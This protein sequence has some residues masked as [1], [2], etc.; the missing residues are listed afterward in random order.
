M[1]ILIGA[2]VGSRQV[3]EN[4]RHARAD[5]MYNVVI[6]SNSNDRQP[7]PRGWRIAVLMD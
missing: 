6:G 2:T 5:V 1:L 3:Q 7:G 4:T